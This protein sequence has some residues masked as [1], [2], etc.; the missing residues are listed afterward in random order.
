MKLFN[1][2]FKKFGTSQYI[3]LHLVLELNNLLSLY[4]K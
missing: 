2:L 3:I 1:L 4:Y